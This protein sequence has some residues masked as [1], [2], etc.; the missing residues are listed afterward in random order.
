MMRCHPIVLL[1]GLL[2]VVRAQGQCV[3]R[4][5]SSCF[6]LT[7]RFSTT[8]QLCL[9]LRFSRS[10]P[11]ISGIPLLRRYFC[12]PARDTVWISILS[13]ISLGA[14]SFFLGNRGDDAVAYRYRLASWRETLRFTL[15][16]VDRFFFNNDRDGNLKRRFR[17]RD[18]IAGRLK[19]KA[20]EL[21]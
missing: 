7:L 17:K 15:A 10:P 20:T 14:V 12:V 21:V 1:A 13:E 19:L 9:T 4:H 18:Y 3:A 8:A 11:Y 16:P 6:I 2:T 5:L